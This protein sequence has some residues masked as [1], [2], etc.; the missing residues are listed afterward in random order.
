MQAG[1]P[2][3]RGKLGVLA[4]DA[5]TAARYVQMGFAFVGIGSDS[6]FI[7]QGGR[8]AIRAVKALT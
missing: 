4:G 6:A 7:A 8:Q 3:S 2:T 5:A 1:A